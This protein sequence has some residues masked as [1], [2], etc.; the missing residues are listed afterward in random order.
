MKSS[1]GHASG[2]RALQLSIALTLVFASTSLAEIAGATYT[3]SSSTTGGTALAD[4]PGTYTDPGNAGFCLGTPTNC[5]NNSGISGSYTFTNISPTDDHITFAF[6]GSTDPVDGSFT[7]NLT[8]FSTVDGSTITGVSWLNGNLGAGN[9][10]T[11][12]LDGDGVTFTGTPNVDYY[13]IGGSFVTF[14]VTTSP[15]PASL[16]LS[17]L[18]LA[19]LA[20]AGIRRKRKA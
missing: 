18:G 3:F 16:L 10:T 2:N 5:A 9:F 14:D 6:Y 15:E 20:I 1:F 13:A 12:S 19:G 17:G 11:A 7:I 8:N 4:T